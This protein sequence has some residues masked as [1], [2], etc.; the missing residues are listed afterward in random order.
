MTNARN[1]IRASALGSYFGV[2][3]NEPLEQLENDMGNE[4]ITFFGAQL[5]AMEVSTLL[6]DGIL[7]IVEARNDCI[8]TDRNTET[9]EAM[10]GKLRVRAD[11]L[12]TI[13]GEYHTVEVKHV[14]S[15]ENPVFNQ[16]F[17][18]QVMSQIIAYREKGYEI[19]KGILACLY[20]G[21]YYQVILELTEE[22]EKDIYI[23]VNTI[24]AILQGELP[25]EM[26]PK[27]ILEKYTTLPEE[28]EEFDIEDTTKV[29]E[30]G[31]VKIKMKELKDEETALVNYLKGKYSALDATV[32]GGTNIKI[33]QTTRKGSYDMAAIITDHP[34]IDIEK[35]RK[36]STTYQTVRVK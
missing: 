23:M 36:E 18:F 20:Q 33:G 16:G 12:T 4:E 15:G 14:A 29:E 2:G 13:N 9:L 3:Y 5:D 21:R 24:V 26:Y 30:L 19:N 10:D 22:L 11:G 34:D 31:K 25:V 35:Y 8:I 1:S 28:P 7:N 32:A 17:H 27:N 6:E